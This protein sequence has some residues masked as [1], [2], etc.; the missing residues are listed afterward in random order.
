[1]TREA[2]PERQVC[3][4]GI[5][6]T[7]AGRPSDRS[8]LQLT[9]DACLQAIGDAGIRVEDVDGLICH[10]GKT[11]E[12]GG[13]S[14]VGTV[15]TMMALGIRPVWTNPSSHEGPGHMAAIFQGIMAI[16]T[17]LCRHVLCFRSV[18]QASARTTSRASTLLT[19]SRARVDP[20]NNAFTVPYHAHSPANLWALYAQAYFD[21]YGVGEEE[22]GWVAVNG[23]RHAAHNPNAIYRT[24]ITIE[25]YLASRMISTP[26]RLFDCDSHIDGSTAILLSHKDAA[27][28][29]RNPPIAIEAMGMSMGAFGEGLHTGD[30]TM[31]PAEKAGDMLWNRTDMTPKDVDCAQIYD[32][33]SIHVWLWLEAVRLC[34]RGEAAGFIA[35]GTRTAI[36]GELPIN[37]SGGQLSAGRFHGYGHT[38]EACAQ[39][40]GR[41]GGRQVKDA[42]TAMTVNGGYGYGAMLLRRD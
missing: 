9:L 27:K 29:L 20:G 17:G 40:W 23:R 4:T 28:D 38:H 6:Q 33:F 19:G 11:T 32:G 34:G 42:C 8:A 37:T 15:E 12:G 21:K 2:N 14:P 7:K 41:G 24:P 1:M 26:L 30:F 25:D 35:G 16:A 36:D 31:T 18:A 39:L 13:I 10:P 3:I 22:L 5:G